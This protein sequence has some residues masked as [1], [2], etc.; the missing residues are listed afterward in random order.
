MRR[1][2]MLILVFILTATVLY[3]KPVVIKFATVAPEGST[4]MNIMEEL[5]DNIIEKTDGQVKF[6]FYPG[7]VMG[8]EID[9]LKKMKINQIHGAGFSTTGLGEIVKETRLLNIPLVFKN[10]DE[11]D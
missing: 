4:W 11:V 3:S 2:L 9:V 5:N 8:D 10:Y 6:K 1:V 7:S